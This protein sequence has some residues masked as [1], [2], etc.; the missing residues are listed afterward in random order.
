VSSVSASPITAGS[1]E[2]TEV[3]EGLNAQQI[4]R[5]RSSEVTSKTCPSGVESSSMAA[6]LSVTSIPSSTRV[7]AASKYPTSPPVEGS[8][9]RMPISSSCFAVKLSEGQVINNNNLSSHDEDTSYSMAIKNTVQR[10]ES[11]HFNNGFSSSCEEDVE[12]DDEGE[13]EEEEDTTTDREVEGPSSSALEEGDSSKFSTVIRRRARSEGTI[14]ESGSES[15]RQEQHA[16]QRGVFPVL[17]QL[18]GMSERQSD[19]EPSFSHTFGNIPSFS[20]YPSI[21]C[22]IVEYL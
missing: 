17:S 1:V 16:E 4:I 18:S 14:M 7:L 5:R 11:D 20:S 9:G 6:R 10:I 19:R 2:Q 12:G 21:K 13:E 8:S 22:D 3:R 15:G